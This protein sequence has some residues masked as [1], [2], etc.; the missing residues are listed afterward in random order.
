M[1]TEHPGKCQESEA[2]LIHFSSPA[3]GRGAPHT[4]PTNGRVAT[5]GRRP[6]SLAGG[7]SCGV[8]PGSP[9]HWNA[10]FL[11]SGEGLRGSTQKG[12]VVTEPWMDNWGQ[13]VH[14]DH[15]QFLPVPLSSRFCLIRSPPTSLSL[16]SQVNLASV[17]NGRSG[18]C[19]LSQ[20]A[21]GTAHQGTWPLLLTGAGA[22]SSTHAGDTLTLSFPR[23]R[24]K[25]RA[26]RSFILRLPQAV[27]C[28]VQ[29]TMVPC[30]LCVP[31]CRQSTHT[32][33]RLLEYMGGKDGFQ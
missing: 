18:V 21:L 5:P 16:V 9:A 7:H 13:S 19:C 10:C 2:F 29:K 28:L 4:H 8:R 20:R 31:T 11:Q 27:H 1:L 14:R 22:L 30:V 33:L 24:I 3:A 17:L 23:L 6:P 25:H 12:N 15:L 26:V 32:Q